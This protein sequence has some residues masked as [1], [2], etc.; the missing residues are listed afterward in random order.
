MDASY[1]Q[2]KRLERWLSQGS[3]ATTRGGGV[4]V[5]SSLS[6]NRLIFHVFDG[7]TPPDRLFR[8][9][10]HIWA[11]SMR[12]HVSHEAWLRGGVH[13]LGT[14]ARARHDA[15]RRQRN[16]EVSRR[17]SVLRRAVYAACSEHYGWLE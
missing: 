4:A 10:H 3:G 2:I 9:T 13:P 1:S 8:M 7:A 6:L 5:G 11:A 15:E 14:R 12:K 17:I 16:A